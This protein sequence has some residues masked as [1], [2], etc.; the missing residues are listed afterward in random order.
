VRR[1]S[2]H[3]TRRPRTRTAIISG[4][5]LSR[6]ISRCFAAGRFGESASR[7]RQR[8]ARL[9]GPGPERKHAVQ[10]DTDVEDSNGKSANLASR[11]T[12]FAARRNERTRPVSSIKAANASGCA[13][14]R[15]RASDYLISSGV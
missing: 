12:P 10:Q 8:Y 7:A 1:R 3:S 5:R 11:S 9:H 2:A 15:S 6:S 4:K 14:D 13:T